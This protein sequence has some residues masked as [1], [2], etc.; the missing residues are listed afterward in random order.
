M[1]LRKT[2]EEEKRE[3][4]NQ[5]Q[6]RQTDQISTQASKCFWQRRPMM[7]HCS[8]SIPAACSAFLLR[9]SDFLFKITL[10]WN[11]PC[12]WRKEKQSSIHDIWTANAAFSLSLSFFL[13]SSDDKIPYLDCLNILPQNTGIGSNRWKHSRSPRFT[14]KAW[15]HAKWKP[16]VT[17][18]DRLVLPLPVYLPVDIL[19]SIILFTFRCIYLPVRKKVLYVS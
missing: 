18:K 8:T 15:T 6:W 9:P 2:K 13:W 3:G 1:G 17:P 12:L 10:L 16:R 19:G 5:L 14:G 7:P 11:L 4:L